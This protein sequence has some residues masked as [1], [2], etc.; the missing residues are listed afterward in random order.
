MPLVQEYDIHGVWPPP[1]EDEVPFRAPHTGHHRS[2]TPSRHTSRSQTF[3]GPFFSHHHAPFSPFQ[4]TDPFTLFNSIFEGSP[5]ASHSRHPSF[6]RP[7]GPFSHME[8]IQAEIED[9]MEDIDRDPFGR[10]G[11][12]RF[13]PMSSM[14]ALGS[15]SF[16]DSSNGRWISE[17]YMTSTVNGITQTIRKQTDVDV[18][19]KLSTVLRRFNAVCRATNMLLARCQ[20]AAKFALSME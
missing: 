14:A 17:S 6:M 11:F 16:N 1:E 5:F 19:L 15:S 9:F 8:R 20:T 10:S 18:S 12:P 4:F 2:Y 7:M 13:S 3:P